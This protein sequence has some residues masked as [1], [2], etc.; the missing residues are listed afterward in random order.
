MKFDINVNGLNDYITKAV[1]KYFKKKKIENN[2]ALC[3]FAGNFL[4]YNKDENKLGYV[5][6]FAVSPPLVETFENKVALNEYND[7]F[8]ATTSKIINELAVKLF[9]EKN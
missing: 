5:T 8:E 6:L 9:K 1:N 2:F 4:F 7:V 3:S